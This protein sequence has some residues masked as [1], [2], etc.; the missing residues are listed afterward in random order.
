LDVEL[1]QSTRSAFAR[2]IK[3]V[4]QASLLG[5]RHLC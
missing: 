4:Y 3:K 5:C 2:L 1:S